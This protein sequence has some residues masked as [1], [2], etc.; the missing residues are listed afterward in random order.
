MTGWK[1]RCGG[2]APGTGKFGEGGGGDKGK[3]VEAPAH[4]RAAGIT[5]MVEDEM[6]PHYHALLKFRF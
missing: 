2:G 4:M 5:H 3:V 6:M 1:P